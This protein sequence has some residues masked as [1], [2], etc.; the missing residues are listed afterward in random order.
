M[1]EIQNIIDQFNPDSDSFKS[2]EKMNKLSNIT[3]KKNESGIDT[4]ALL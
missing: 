2:H 3:W 4:T 1:E